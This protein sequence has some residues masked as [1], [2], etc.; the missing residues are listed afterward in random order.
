MNMNA[1]IFSFDLVTLLNQPL[2]PQCLCLL[3]GLLFVVEAGVDGYR[4]F[5]NT[6][7]LD[8]TVAP[9]QQVT[10]HRQAAS[11]KMPLFGLYIPSESK[12]AIVQASSLDLKLIGIMYSQ[13]NPAESQALIRLASGEELSYVVGDSLPGGATIHRIQSNRV[14]IE[15][16]GALEALFLAKQTLHFEAPAKP[17]L[18][19]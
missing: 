16:H 7:I 1:K 19:E 17:L 14:L 5:R 6:E 15:Y 2:L 4:L 18:T 8:V 13:S 11:L 3:F 10:P 9:I 12:Q